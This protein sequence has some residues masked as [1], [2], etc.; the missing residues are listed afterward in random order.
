MTPKQKYSITDKNSLE[1][2][3]KHGSVL[4]YLSKINACKPRAATDLYLFCEWAHQSPEELL[5]LKTN[6]EA[7]E[8]ENLLDRFVRSNVDM[9]D[10]RKW[11]ITMKVRGFFRANYRDLQSA[12]GKMEYP[13]GQDQG[14]PTKK[15]R[16]AVLNACYTPRDKALVVV[17]SCTGMALETLS[18]LHWSHFEENWQ[19]QELPHISV[20]SEML[21][22]HGKGKY[23]GVRQETFLTPEA[24][25]ALI[26][27]REW[28]AK[29]FN[30]TWHQDDYVFLQVKRNVGKPLPYL[31]LSKAM[32]KLSRRAGVSFSVHDGRRIV[33]TA[34]ESVG[35]SSNWIKKIKG[36]K[37]SGEDSP[38]SKP[39]IEQLQQKYRE[40]LPELEFLSEQN[41]DLKRLED[42]EQKISEKDQV[43]EA[44]AKNGAELKTKVEQIE[45]SKD[46]LKALLKRVLELEKKL[47]EK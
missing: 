6:Y 39:A 42:M 36:R 45:G 13:P 14:S 2:S 18:E 1:W 34:L 12:A 9:P 16:R 15:N 37:V 47:G 28:F 46:S 35:T 41:V 3:Q 23:R 7:T 4:T 20:P 32:L 26:E 27:Y 31:M 21:K 10:T 25:Q 17:S 33:Q 40:A 8:A 44:L 38:Y 11:Q 29:T 5:S 30:Y 19:E 22:G 24:K 43:I